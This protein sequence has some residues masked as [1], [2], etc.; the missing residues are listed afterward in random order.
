MIA[1]I[2]MHQ[3]KSQIGILK[4]SYNKRI[5][6][7]RKAL[8]NTQII[9]EEIKI[10]H[11]KKATLRIAYIDARIKSLS[12]VINKAVTNDIKAD[13]I[14]GKIADIAGMRIVVNNLTD[15][16]PLIKEIKKDGRLKILEKERHSGQKPYRAVHLKVI[17]KVSY[18]H[19]EHEV[20]IEIQI[21]TLLQDAW[22]IL[23]HHDQYKNQASLPPWPGR[24]LYV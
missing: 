16:N 6:L 2:R 3:D 4:K 19:G 11:Q 18:K 9:V 8:S 13:D 5:S 7:Y 14:F 17:L 12:S 21:R 24:S 1:E 22:A 23:T 20:P 10:K 15:I